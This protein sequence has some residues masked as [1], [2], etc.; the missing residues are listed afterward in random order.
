MP[1][2]GTVESAA[3]RI[4]HPEAGPEAGPLVRL[5]GEIRSALAERHVRTFRAAGATDVEIVA[6]ADDDVP[7]GRRLQRLRDAVVAG[8]AAGGGAARGEGAG[9]RGPGGSGAD[10][11]RPRDAVRRG[12]VVLGSG[13]V[14]LL[15]PADARR[16]LEV[17][18][19]DACVALANNRFSADIVAIARVAELPE[20]PDLPS[21]NA[22]PRWLAERAG[23]SVRDLAGVPRLAFDI[24]APLDAALLGSRPE[25]TRD[26]FLLVRD[27]MERLA[28]LAADPRAELVVVGR[29]SSRTVAMLERRTRCRIR[30]IIE[31]RG[32]RASS[33][34]ALGDGPANSPSLVSDPAPT[35][36]PRQRP[37]R[38]ILGL[39]L[40]RDGPDALGGILRELGDGAVVDTRVLLGHR[41]GID[42]RG[43]PSAGDRFASDL[44]DASSI[45][46]PWLRALTSSAADA[47]IPILLGGH[48]LVGPGIG[49]ALGLEHPARRPGRPTLGQ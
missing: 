5:L 6:T 30:A 20:L 13:S 38:S 49:R 41:F 36:E 17:A 46:D 42:E 32:M 7:F 40:D 43:W 16:F 27:R 44:L 26:A 47:G 9:G 12:L 4:L 28:A 48:S 15:R 18:G 24:D 23:W 29:T 8:H 25:A 35:T 14:P 45:A 1:A 33:S 34:L 2:P 22:L 37:P 19:A 10:G 11:H 39:V 3:V 21:D 31:E